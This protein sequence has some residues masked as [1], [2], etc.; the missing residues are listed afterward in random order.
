M[1]KSRSTPIV[2]NARKPRNPYVAAG[3][4]RRAGTHDAARLSERQQARRALKREL[5]ALHPPSP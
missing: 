2:I 3:R 5:D 1:K 4:F